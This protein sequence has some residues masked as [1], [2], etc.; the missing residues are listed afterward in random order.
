MLKAKYKCTN[1]LK[2]YINK[3]GLKYISN[4]ILNP[5]FANK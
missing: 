5:G 4:E 2:R 3:K 1:V